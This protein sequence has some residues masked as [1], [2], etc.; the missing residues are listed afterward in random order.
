MVCAAPRVI[1][2]SARSEDVFF[3]ARD[4]MLPSVLFALRQTF[5]RR[6]HRPDLWCW[7]RGIPSLLP[8]SLAAASQHRLRTEITAMAT[9]LSNTVLVPVSP[10]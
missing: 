5:V 2:V 4:V 10:V 3:Q 6:R 9:L 7:L 1:A 8:P